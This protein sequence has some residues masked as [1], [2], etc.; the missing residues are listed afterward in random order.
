MYTKNTY[1]SNSSLN[2][3]NR[4]MSKDWFIVDYKLLKE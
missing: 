1:N 3:I 2:L 4:Q